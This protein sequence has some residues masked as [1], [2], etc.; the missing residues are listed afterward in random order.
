MCADLM[1]DGYRLQDSKDS[2][3]T[4]VCRGGTPYWCG[5]NLYEATHDAF[6]ALAN[7]DGREETSGDEGIFGHFWGVN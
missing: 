2:S 4:G 7:K 1:H 3:H 5:A 6:A